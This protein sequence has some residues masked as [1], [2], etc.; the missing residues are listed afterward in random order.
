[1]KSLGPDT[2]E[3]PITDPLSGTLAGKFSHADRRKFSLDMDYKE[4]V[5]NQDLKQLMKGKLHAWLTQDNPSQTDRKMALGIKGL[6]RKQ[7]I[8]SKGPIRK[9]FLH[10]KPMTMT[11]NE[12]GRP[13]QDFLKNVSPMLLPQITRD[14]IDHDDN[15]TGLRRRSS[16]IISAD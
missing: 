16:Q 8:N 9:A 10:P 2:K 7:I 14:N 6:P 5:R 3:S 13:P 4:K 15:E 12:I 11:S 1:M